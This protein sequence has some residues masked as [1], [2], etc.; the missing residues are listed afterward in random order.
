MAKNNRPEWL[1]DG[2]GIIDIT[3]S[4][5][6]KVSGAETP[7]LRMREPTVND[8][9]IAEEYKGSDAQKE[10]MMV[11]NLCEVSPEDIRAL[12]LRDYKRLQTAFL[13]F[14]SD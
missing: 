14:S 11:A 2:E 9:L 5:P 7:K 6:A 1:E 4:R 3:L 8:Q 13:R 12:P 10:V